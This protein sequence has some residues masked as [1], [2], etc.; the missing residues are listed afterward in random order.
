MRCLG[1]ERSLDRPASVTPAAGTASEYFPILPSDRVPGFY[2][3]DLKHWKNPMSDTQDGL[4]SN[5]AE[6]GSRN[7]D[8][9]SG[10]MVGADREAYPDFG[11]D[12]GVELGGHTLLSRTPASEGRRSLFRR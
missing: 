4:P 10:P 1:S 5:H 6:A 2:H 11:T 9:A 3:H 8:A 7:P 12:A